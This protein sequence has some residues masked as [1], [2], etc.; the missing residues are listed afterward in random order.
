MYESPRR[1][2][3]WRCIPLGDGW[4]GSKRGDDAAGD[5]LLLLLL[6]LL[7]VLLPT[8][9]PETP[10]TDTVVPCTATHNKHGMQQCSAKVGVMTLARAAAAPSHCQQRCTRTHL[11]PQRRRR[12]GHEPHECPNQPHG[13]HRAAADGERGAPREP[14]VAPE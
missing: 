13:H 8:V 7:L 9:P 11:R 14:R 6:L 3:D 4:Y 1:K 10:V 2:L 5:D 12:R